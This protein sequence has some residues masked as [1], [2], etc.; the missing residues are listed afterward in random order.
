MDQRT[1][2]DY[3]YLNNMS[4]LAFFS[5]SCLCLMRTSILQLPFLVA[6]RSFSPSVSSRLAPYRLRG[7]K[8][9]SVCA[10]ASRFYDEKPEMYTL[11]IHLAKTAAANAFLDGWKTV[12]MC[13][14]YALMASYMP[15]ARRWDEDRSRF[16]SGI[17]IR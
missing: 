7:V 2:C 10:L 11:A 5:P 16:Y 1:S 8:L 13:Q 12:E 4:E 14:A 9:L 3:I 17:A 15:P 6:V